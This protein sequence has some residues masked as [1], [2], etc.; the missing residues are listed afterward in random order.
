[1]NITEIQQTYNDNDELVVS[2]KID[3]IPFTNI[4]HEDDG[5]SINNLIVRN[6]NN[7][8]SGSQSSYKPIINAVDI[9]WNEAVVNTGFLSNH[10]KTIKTT[11]DLLYWLQQDLIT[12]SQ[13]VST[14][15]G[16][17]TDLQSTNEALTERIVKLETLVSGLYSALADDTSNS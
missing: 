13:Q 5:V 1:M 12:A 16:Q 7:W 6:N 10:S 15:E 11:G 4:T 8:K 9:D 17:V 3:G 14:L 2:A